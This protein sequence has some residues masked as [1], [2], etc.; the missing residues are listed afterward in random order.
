MYKTLLNILLKCW[1]GFKKVLLITFCKNMFKTLL[2]HFTEMLKMFQK[3]FCNI[4][5]LSFM[6]MFQKYYFNTKFLWKGFKNV[7]EI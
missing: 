2:K 6:K 4:L 3:C 5:T 7:L 1:K